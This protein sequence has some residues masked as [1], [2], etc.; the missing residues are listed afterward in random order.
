[1]GE[2]PMLGAARILADQAGEVDRHLE[3]RAVAFW[4][5]IGFFDL[6]AA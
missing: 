4:S 1:M 2:A 6:D 5:W 3:A